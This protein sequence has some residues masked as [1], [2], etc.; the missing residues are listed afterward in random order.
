MV[1]SVRLIVSVL[2]M[3][4]IPAMTATTYPQSKSS[5]AQV[6]AREVAP[7]LPADEAGGVAVAVRIGG[8]TLF[9]NFGLADLAGRRPVTSDLLFNLASIS[10]VFDATL[11]AQAVLRGEMSLDDPVVK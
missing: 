5:V 10:K 6:V 4:T 7:L 8:R 11:L 2:A 9:Y 1:A 3:A